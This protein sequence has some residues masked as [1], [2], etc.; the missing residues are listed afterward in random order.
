MQRIKVGD[1]VQ[2]RCDNVFN[3]NIYKLMSSVYCLPS[4]L[5]TILGKKGVVTKILSVRVYDDLTDTF[6]YTKLF[7][8]KIE[9]IDYVFPEF[10][11]NLIENPLPPKKYL[12]Y[13]IG[14]YGDYT[15]YL[16]PNDAMLYETE[17]ENNMYIISN[18][19]FVSIDEEDVNAILES[20]ND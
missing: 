6:I 18:G 10:M 11:F 14:K 12:K 4:K 13:I 3:S 5:Q 8:V 1:T 15:I 16:L 7:V 9:K 2:I 19:E 17:D 20:C